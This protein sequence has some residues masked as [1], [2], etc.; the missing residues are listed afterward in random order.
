M[1]YKT[2]LTNPRAETVA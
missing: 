2:V 1:I